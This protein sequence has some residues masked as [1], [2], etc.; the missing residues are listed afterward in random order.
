MLHTCIHFIQGPTCLVSGLG[1]SR[2]VSSPRNSHFFTLPGT[3][4]ATARE[5]M[6]RRPNLRTPL[7]H[8]CV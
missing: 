2:K 4:F 7:M 5:R 3:V 6:P 8:V 1:G